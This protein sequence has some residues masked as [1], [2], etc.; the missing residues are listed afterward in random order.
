V[1]KVAKYDRAFTVFA[2]RLIS[3]VESEPQALKRG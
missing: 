1:T 2:E 3:C